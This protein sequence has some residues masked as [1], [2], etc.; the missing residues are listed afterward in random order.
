MTKKKRARID[1]VTARLLAEEAAVL[2]RHGPTWKGLEFASAIADEARTFA[3]EVMERLARGERVEYPQGK[4]QLPGTASDQ[5]NVE[6]VRSAMYFPRPAR[7]W[8]EVFE[9]ARVK[10]GHADNRDIRRSWHEYWKRVGAIP[11]LPDEMRRM[12]EGEE[13]P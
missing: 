6:A 2:L 11:V 5:R 8:N 3:A 4:K 10:L 9:R 13:S 12:R 1:A 7:T